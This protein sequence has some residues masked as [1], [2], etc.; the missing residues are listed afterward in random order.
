MFI[1][2]SPDGGHTVLYFQLV[3][4]QKFSCRRHDLTS[5]LSFFILYSGEQ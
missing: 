4:G 1:D 3:R 2:Y 5:F